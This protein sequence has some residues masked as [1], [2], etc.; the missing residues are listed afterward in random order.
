M[1][2]QP[3]EVLPG[4]WQITLPLPFELNSVNTYLLRRAGGWMLI[5]T[6]LCTQESYNELQAQLELIGISVRDISE[7]L[8]THTHPDH[9]GQTRRLLEETGARLMLHRDELDQVVR[10]ARSGDPPRWLNE[11][12]VTAG[13]PPELIERIEKSFSMIRGNF[14]EINPDHI[15]E[16]GEVLES[17]IGPLELLCTPGHSP[18]HMCLY[19]HEKRVLVSGDHILQFITPNI[20]WIPQRDP[21]GEFFSSLDRVR[22]FEI[23]TLLPGHGAPFRGH[24]EWISET[25]AHHDD[26]CAQIRASLATSP[27][28]AHELVGDLWARPL[29]PFHHRFAVFEVLAHLEYLLRREQISR[30]DSLDGP[31]VWVV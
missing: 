28:T 13:V 31:Q 16:D 21:L 24:R 9:V 14:H 2:R 3:L 10:I 29:A 6:G 23:D 1:L 11:A 8:L 19:S 20:G 26:R 22:P 12:L 17:G 25:R 27:R 15:L 30:H 18:G 5:D 4:L 7:I